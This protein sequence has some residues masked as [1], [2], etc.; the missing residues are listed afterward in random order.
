[1]NEQEAKS[2]PAGGQGDYDP[3]VAMLADF[4]EGLAIEEARKQ[5]ESEKAAKAA[6]TP[7]PTRGELAGEA[8]TLVVVPDAS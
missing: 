3:I 6:L 5:I 1:M 2:E 4:I 7:E 8:A